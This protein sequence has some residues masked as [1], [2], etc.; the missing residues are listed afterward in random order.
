MC[1][2][3]G[4]NA[5]LVVVIRPAS[6]RGGKLGRKSVMEG[7]ILALIFLGFLVVRR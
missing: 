4:T 7:R 1:K 2:G 5:M 6:S 3:P